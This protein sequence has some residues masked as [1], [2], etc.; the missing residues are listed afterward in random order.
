MRGGCQL[1]LVEWNG[2]HFVLA[3]IANI[4]RA[5]QPIVRRLVLQIERPVFGVRQL[6]VD[7]VAAEQER[8]EPVSRRIRARFSLCDVGQQS[9]KR[10]G[11]AGGLGRSAGAKRSVQGGPSGCED[12][13]YKGRSQSDA[14][15]P[16]EARAGGWRELAEEFT[17]IVVKPEP[18]AHGEL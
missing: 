7:I 2:Q 11:A 13:L 9:L 16:V 12:G 1:R 17:A 18:G 4:A 8:T 10:R 15:G 14:E 6:V 5:Q 3:V